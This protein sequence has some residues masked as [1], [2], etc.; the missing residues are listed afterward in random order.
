[1]PVK[2]GD[3]QEGADVDHAVDVEA[4]DEVEVVEDDFQLKQKTVTKTR[5]VMLVSQ[6]HQ[7]QWTKAEGD[8]K[9]DERDAK[10]EGS[11]EGEDL[12]PVRSTV[13]PQ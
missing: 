13:T 10:A 2:D 6:E 9:D 7:N 1:M 12:V 11:I 4:K 5:T 8:V 3:V